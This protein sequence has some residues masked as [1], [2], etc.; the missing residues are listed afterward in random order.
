MLNDPTISDMGDSLAK[1][2]TNII[3]NMSTL[4][5]NQFPALS[6]VQVQY[7]QV[8]WQWLIF[9]ASIVI[10]G[11]F[12]L[13]FTIVQSHLSAT[14]IWKISSLALLFHPLQGWSDED[15]NKDG[16]SEMMESAKLMRGQLV[17]TEDA[18]Y[19]MVRR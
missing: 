1:G 7:I 2:L 16:R 11:L 6:Y 8:R 12:L 9:P 19:R 15:L 17:Y 18:G 4:Y 10:L 3:R 5:T 13:V 14:E